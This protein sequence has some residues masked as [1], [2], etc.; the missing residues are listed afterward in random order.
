MGLPPALGEEGRGWSSHAA[1]LGGAGAMEA[2]SS[3]ED[4]Y[5]AFRTDIEEDPAM[6]HHINIYKDKHRIAVDEDEESDDAGCPRITLAEM[7]DDLDLGGDATG[8]AGA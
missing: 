5:D 4:E 3:V 7:L 2:A 6:R 1:P 8:G